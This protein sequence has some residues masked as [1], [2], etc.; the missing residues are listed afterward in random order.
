MLVLLFFFILY[1]YLFSCF[2]SFNSSMMLYAFPP[3]IDIQ[4]SRLYT[5]WREIIII[6]SIQL[7][8]YRRR[9]VRKCGRHQKSRL[10]AVVNSITRHPWRG[11]FNRTSW[12][13][14]NYRIIIKTFLYIDGLKLFPLLKVFLF[15]SDHIYKYIF[16]KLNPSTYLYNNIMILLCSHKC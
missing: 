7:L 13:Y 8:F 14:L 6:E 16:L 3:E 9:S 4:Q 15:I 2:L 1:F 5:Y 12:F 10:T 11:V